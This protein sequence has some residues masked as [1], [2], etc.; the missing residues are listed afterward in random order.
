MQ[1]EKGETNNWIMVRFVWVNT[2]L[3][4][5]IYYVVCLPNSNIKN[6]M[7]TILMHS[8]NVYKSFFSEISLYS[9]VG[10]QRMNVEAEIKIYGKLLFSYTD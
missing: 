5:F 9:Y 4:E 8:V 10:F 1:L 3:V 2:N 7:R 6:L